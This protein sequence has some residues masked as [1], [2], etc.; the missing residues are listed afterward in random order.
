MDVL[1][2]KVEWYFNLDY[3]DGIEIFCRTPDDHVEHVQ[4]ILTLLNATGVTVNLR[5]CDFF[6]NGIDYLGDVIPPGLLK[7]LARTTDAVHGL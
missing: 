2:T 3:L 5:K 4:Q 1:L 7:V 6:T